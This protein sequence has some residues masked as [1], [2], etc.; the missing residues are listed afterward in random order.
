[1][2]LD[3][4]LYGSPASLLLIGLL[5]SS[6]RFQQQ[7]AKAKLQLSVFKFSKKQATAQ[8]NAQECSFNQL[9]DMTCYNRILHDTS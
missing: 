1:M 9:Y 6:R 8:N 3:L 5:F 2:L 4:D 7:Q